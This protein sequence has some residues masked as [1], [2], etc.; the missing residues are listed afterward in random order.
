MDGLEAI[1]EGR[2]QVDRHLEAARPAVTA[3][4][5]DLDGDPAV[6]ASGA[7]LQDKRYAVAVHTAGSPSRT[8]GRPRSTGRP[9]RSPAGTRWKWSPGGWCGTA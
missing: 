7:W 3:A 6:T 9:G 4:R 8:A 2:V 1:V 5:P